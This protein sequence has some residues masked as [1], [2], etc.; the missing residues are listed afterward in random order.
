[1]TIGPAPSND[2]EPNCT[3]SRAGARDGALA[4]LPLLA[5]YVPFALVIGSVAADHGRPLAGWAG[6]WLIFGGSAHLAALRT[7][8]QAGPVA[9]ILTGLLVNARLA[10]VQRVARPAAGPSNP[11]GSGRGRGRSD[12]RPHVGG[13]RA[14]RR[15]SAPIPASSAATSSAPG[16]R[17][18]PAG[19]LRS[20]S[21]R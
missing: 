6:S 11:A 5:A 19:R 8:D 1:M 7:L 14:A 3:E 13:R 15:R 17:S 20:R 9:A 4:M 12:H 16:S 2:L 21:A 18:A 10:R